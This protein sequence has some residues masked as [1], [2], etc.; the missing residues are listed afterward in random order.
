MIL[1]Q[2]VLDLQITFHDT[3]TPVRYTVLYQMHK[4]Y[5]VL[6]Q[7]PVRYTALYQ[8]PEGYIVL[9]QTLAGYTAHHCTTDI[10]PHLLHHLQKCITLCS[11]TY[12]SVRLTTICIDTDIHSP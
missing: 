8:T 3:Q 11:A 7:I 1:N 4:G 12:Q 9:H 5:T 10:S 2:Q 6:C